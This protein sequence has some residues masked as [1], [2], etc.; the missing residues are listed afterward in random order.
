MRTG[1]ICTPYVTNERTQCAFVI[2]DGKA[3]SLATQ[4]CKAVLLNIYCKTHLLQ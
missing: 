3:D 1:G 4:Y 2:D